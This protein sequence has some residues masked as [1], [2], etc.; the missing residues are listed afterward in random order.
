MPRTESLPFYESVEKPQDNCAVVGVFSKTYDIPSSVF[1]GLVELN[2]RGQEGSGVLISNGEE[3]ALT[4]GPGLASIVFGMTNEL[5]DL[6]NAFVGIGHNRYSTSGSLAELQPFLDSGIGI[7][8]NGN[9]TNIEDL[10]RKY[11]IPE[12]IDGA[13]SD[14]RIALA[15]I[16]NMEGDAAGKIVKGVEQFEGAYSMVFA[17]KDAL[18]ASRDPHGF[19]PLS[20]GRLKD[21]GGYAVISETSGFSTGTEFIRDVLPGETIM[22]NGDGITTIGK[23]KD[24]NLAQ[25]VFELIY[26]SRPD[27]NVFGIPVVEFRLREGEILSRHMPDVDIIMPVPRSGISAAQ[28]VASSEIAKEKRIPYIDGIYTNPYRNVADGTRTFIRPNGRDKAATQKYSINEA[29]VRGKRVVIVDDSIVRGS[30]RIVVDKLREAGAKEVH[31]L[32]ASPPI[33]HGCFYGVDFGKDEVLADRMPDMEERR[34]YLGLDSL[35][36]LTEAELLEA[37]LGNPV[38]T[39]GD[40]FENNGFCGGCFTGRYPTEVSDT[41][42]K[43]N[44]VQHVS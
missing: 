42:I 43:I 35:Y 41:I 4:K 21:S 12:E 1:N 23:R 11:D 19:R 36:Y 34:K 44:E 9:L 17:T 22:I 26:I 18:F 29:V 40:I 37:A 24:A 15:V 38:E 10:R 33:E 14:T 3:M 6:D 13:R 30:L 27:S 2:H 32:I 39:Q 16:N 8:H 5:P 28:G 25:C 7:A 20:I 31:A